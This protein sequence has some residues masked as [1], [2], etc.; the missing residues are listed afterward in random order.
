MYGEVLIG[1]VAYNFYLTEFQRWLQ[2]LIMPTKNIA[3]QYLYV[4]F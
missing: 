2:S 3:M 1:L 4:L